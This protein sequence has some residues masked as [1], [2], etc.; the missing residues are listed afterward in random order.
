VAVRPD[1]HV[2]YGFHA[3]QLE[4]WGQFK[5]PNIIDDH[6]RECLVIV[7]DATLSSRNVI[8]ELMQLIAWRGKP[9]KINVDNGTEFI[10]TALQLRD[11]EMGIELHFN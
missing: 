7:M 11:T 10:S 1:H 3:R 2:E 5:T 8:W 4:K 9:V 6:N